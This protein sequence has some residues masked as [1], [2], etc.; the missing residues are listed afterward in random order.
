MCVCPSVS[1][2]NVGDTCTSKSECAADECCQIINIVVMSRKRQ[3]AILPLNQ[4][5]AGTPSKY[6]GG[7]CRLSHLPR[8]C[9]TRSQ[10][11][12]STVRV[13]FFVCFL[14]WFVFSFWWWYFCFQ[15]NT[16]THATATFRVV[17]T[18][19]LASTDFCRKK[20]EKTN[21]QKMF[22]LIFSRDN[23]VAQ[24]NSWYATFWL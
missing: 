19:D 20:K 5:E 22:I 6:A 24:D 9:L 16:F 11:N 23:C 1:Q 8:L 12:I 10:W 3:A 17:I 4:H 18:D 21:K 7:V 13:G 15:T 14:F 2:A